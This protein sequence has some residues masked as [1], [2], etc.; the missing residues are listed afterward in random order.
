MERVLAGSALQSC[1]TKHLASITHGGKILLLGEGPGRFLSEVIR[2]FPVAEITCVDS[3][4]AM[5]AQ[6]RSANPSPHVL[7]V[8]ADASEHHLGIECY[9][10]IASHFFL[11]CFPPDQL[12]QLISRI[13]SALKPGG[14][15]LISDFRLPPSG[16]QR[17]RAA[18]LLKFMYLFFRTV[19]ALP[20]RQLTNPDP[21]L[22]QNGLVLLKRHTANFGLLHSDLWRKSQIRNRQV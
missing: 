8:H 21:F 4:A 11:D 17:W 19:T 22:Q 6:A 16:P 13:A 2:S 7:F 10:T 18:I 12:R 9:D 5:L 15:W 14:L 20:A 3:S 1:R